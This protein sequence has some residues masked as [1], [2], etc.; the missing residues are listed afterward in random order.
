MLHVAEA[1]QFEQRVRLDRA[2]VAEAAQVVAQQVHDHQVFGAVLGVAEQGAA[3]G[4]VFHLGG[5]AGPGALDRLGHH[6]PPLNTQKALRR[7]A[8]HRILLVPEEAGVGRRVRRHQTLEAAQGVAVPARFEALRVVDLVAVAGAQVV[9]NARQRLKVVGGALLG[10]E[11]AAQLKGRA[12]FRHRAG[13]VIEQVHGDARALPGHRQPVQQ[14]AGFVGHQA[15]GEPAAF[16]EGLL[17]ARGQG[18][19]VRRAV[20]AQRQRRR[21]QGLELAVSSHHNLHRLHAFDP[22]F[23]ER[24]RR[25]GRP[26]AGSA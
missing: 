16:G 10:F 3:Q 5:A 25:G 4:P 11:L 9:L 26:A 19:D 22:E 21:P 14:G 12:L 20:G 8:E 2:G 1:A 17:D 7:H 24:W 18:F 6:V 13:R 15:A 23:S